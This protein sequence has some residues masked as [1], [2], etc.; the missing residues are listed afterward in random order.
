MARETA[1][2]AVVPDHSLPSPPPHT[3]PAPFS[4]RHSLLQTCWT[5]NYFANIPGTVWASALADP[6]AWEVLSQEIHKLQ[7]PTSFRSLFKSHPLN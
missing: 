6:S 1:R 3:P 7:L 4:P 5:P 2:N